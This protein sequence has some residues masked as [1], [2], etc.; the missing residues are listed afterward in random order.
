[1]AVFIR[2]L[3]A[4]A[5][6]VAK[7]RTRGAASA[8]FPMWLWRLQSVA[9]AGIREM[10]AALRNCCFTHVVGFFTGSGSPEIRIVM[11]SGLAEIVADSLRK[12][13]AAPITV[14]SRRILRCP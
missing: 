2:I 6:N 14:L 13:T 8:D 1:M 5:E 10:D 9:S 4:S 12:V 11:G 3:D 7:M